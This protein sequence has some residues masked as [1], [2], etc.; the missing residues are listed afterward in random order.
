MVVRILPEWEWPRIAETGSCVDKR[1]QTLATRGYVVSVEAWTRI[2][3]IGF[4]FVAQDS[5]PHIDG[6]W[7][8]D[9]YRGTVSVPRKLLRGFSAALDLLGSDRQVPLDAASA[10]MRPCARRLHGIKL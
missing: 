3:A 10:W 6:L 2:L 8:D 9:E 5:T 4:V 7:I 1:W